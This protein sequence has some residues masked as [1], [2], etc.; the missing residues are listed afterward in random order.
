M[1]PAFA[2]RASERKISAAFTAA[3]HI[4]LLAALL[5]FRPDLTGPAEPP[6][7]LAVDLVPAP[8][9][10]APVAEP[11]PVVAISD[12]T[13]A[14]RRQRVDPSEAGT[15]A[16]RDVREEMD[17]TLGPVPTATFPPVPSAGTG[18]APDGSADMGQAGSGAGRGSGGGTGSGTGASAALDAPHWITRPTLAR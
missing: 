9:P 5:S 18:L 14:P 4:A 10:E 17:R 16:R 7:P 1:Q 11:V 3:I 8:A 13:A 6:P 15:P 12:S 2:N